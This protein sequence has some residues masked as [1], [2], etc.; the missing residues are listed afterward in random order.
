MSE[1]NMCD[2]CAGTGKPISGKPCMCGGTGRMSD[3]AV[4]LREQLVAEQTRADSAEAEVSRLTDALDT[5]QP[6]YMQM[7]GDLEEAKKELERLQK[8]RDRYKSAIPERCPVTGR[9]FF[10][11]IATDETGDNWVPTYGGPF[12]S[13][14]IP[15]ATDPRKER[16][17]YL[18][19]EFHQQRCDH[20]E[21]SWVDGTESI[22]LVLIDDELLMDAE[23]ESNEQKT[24]AESA[25]KALE[26][27]REEAKT[28]ADL[29]SLGDQR[30]LASDGP[31]AGK[32][33]IDFL[34][35]QESATLYQSARAILAVIKRS[36]DRS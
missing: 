29:L 36:G 35:V 15:V 8:D 17:K 20:D 22:G 7:S 24:R 16:G 33:A 31:A 25:E 1:N 34:T 23:E 26:G 11:L 4:Y 27:V 3:A 28:V 12:D 32:N 2:A 18:Y 10:M 14:T 19:A 21:G 5:V 13:Y 9:D 30:I 6:R